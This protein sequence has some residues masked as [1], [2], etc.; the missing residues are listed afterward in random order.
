MRLE[1]IKGK[2][3]VVGDNV[4]TDAIIPSRY[5]TLT[6][7]DELGK[8]VLEGLDPLIPKK[9]SEMNLSILVAG[10]NF[11]CGSSREHAVLALLG[12][13]IKAVIAESYARIFFRNA[14]NRGL[15]AIEASN[16]RSKVRDGDDVT[17]Y[18]KKH[19]I[20]L[21]SGEE[22]PF[23]PV[24][25]EVIEIIEAGGLIEYMKAKVNKHGD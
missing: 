16:L 19:V 15:L 14:I 6:N 2:V 24:P 25:N 22:I 3:L 8:H 10:K 20:K 4:D 17:I 1:V 18:V 13:G 12:A 11:G 5:L 9:I 7:P 21:S 23:K